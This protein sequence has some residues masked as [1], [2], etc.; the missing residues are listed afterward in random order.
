MDTLLQN[1]AVREDGTIDLSELMRRLAERFV[2]DLMDIQ[3]DELFGGVTPRNGYRERTLNTMVGPIT[4]RIPKLREGTYFPSDVI[5]PYS[6]TDRALIGAIAEMYVNGVSTRKVEKVAAEMG[7]ES[8]SSSQVSRMCATLD[9][10]VA[11]LRSARFSGMRFPYLWLDATYMKCRENGHVANRAVVTAIAAGEDGSRQFVGLGV[12]DAESY[13]S[14]KPFL[15][16]L[17]RRGVDGVCCVTSDAHDGLVR[18]IREVFP[19][20]AWQRCIVHFER[21]LADLAPGKGQKAKVLAAAKAVFKETDPAMVREAYRQAACEL[22]GICPKAARAMEDA[23]PD[24]LAYLD[25]PQA[26][27]TWLRTNNVQERANREIK[28]RAKVVQSFPS[29]ESMI[30]LVGAVLVEVNEE[31]LAGSFIDKRSLQGVL[32]REQAHGAASDEVKAKAFTLVKAAIESA[33]RAA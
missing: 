13:A 24:V 17:R 18:A 29:A 12:V 25:F 14:W 26:H 2:N 33:G 3:V 32:R 15:L 6:R 9:E 5:R 4:L 16:D 22:E 23:E 19:G 10:E 7:F 27:R 21:N 30:R 8:L 28:R 11:G 20:A 1:V 31:W